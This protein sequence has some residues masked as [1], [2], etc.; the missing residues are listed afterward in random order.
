MMKKIMVSI[1]GWSSA[2]FIFL[3]ASCFFNVSAR[4][5]NIE[6][7]ESAI[8]FFA[9]AALANF[10]ANRLG[11]NI[12]GELNSAA[13]FFQRLK[14]SMSN[15]IPPV[16]QGGLPAK[17]R[18]SRLTHPP[19]RLR[20]YLYAIGL[21]CFFFAFALE[22]IADIRGVPMSGQSLL[23]IAKYAFASLGA[24]SLVINFLL[25]FLF[26]IRSKR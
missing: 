8:L 9:A 6:R 2:L 16:V 24:I 22:M 15:H 13:Q 26:F 4:D 1:L 17:K 7:I 11:W 21:I 5:I 18:T 3:G 10:I 12:P 20:L 25:S 23:N 19:I 14:A